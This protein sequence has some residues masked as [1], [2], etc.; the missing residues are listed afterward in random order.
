MVLR[1]IVHSHMRTAGCDRRRLAPLGRKTVYA[2]IF[3]L[4]CS[5]WLLFKAVEA[6]AFP[7]IEDFEITRAT[8]MGNKVAIHGTFNKV[9]SC[10][11]VDVVA[12][13]GDRFINVEMSG[14]PNVRGLPP[15]RL[16]RRQTFGPWLLV[17]KVPRLELHARHTCITGVVT[18]RLFSGAIVL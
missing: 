16:V 7:V 12:Y 4:A 11:L 14:H 3:A 8:D 5:A 2:L 13:S 10:D 15:T 6:T 17:P 1:S 9:R 18:T